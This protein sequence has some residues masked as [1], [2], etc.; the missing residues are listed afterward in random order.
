MLTLS[1]GLLQGGHGAADFIGSAE[2]YRNVS[3]LQFLLIYIKSKPYA[4]VLNRSMEIPS[5]N[6]HC[7]LN[8]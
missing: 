1:F 2:W 7:C 6:H 3:H 8:F 5:E 4:V